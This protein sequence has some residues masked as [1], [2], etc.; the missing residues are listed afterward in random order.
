MIPKQVIA[1]DMRV[2][3]A[4]LRGLIKAGGLEPTTAALL[5]TMIRL[6]E[7]LLRQVNNT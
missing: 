5:K 4:E 2:V 1:R 6:V 3:L 7:L